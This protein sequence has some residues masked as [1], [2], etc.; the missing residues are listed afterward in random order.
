MNH[1]AKV[2]ATLVKPSKLEAATLR[3]AGFSP[4]PGGTGEVFDRAK[5]GARIVKMTNGKWRTGLSPDRPQGVDLA[6]VEAAIG[7][8]GA[9][10]LP[11]PALEG[12]SKSV[13]TINKIDAM[14]N[15]VPCQ[16]SFVIGH[17]AVTKEGGKKTFYL[18]RHVPSG[19]T[20]S[21]CGIVKLKHA[22]EGAKAVHAFMDECPWW[23]KSELSEVFSPY[24]RAKALGRVKDRI[25]A[26]ADRGMTD[27][28][29]LARL[30][31]EGVAVR[32]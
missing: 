25:F 16:A 23:A 4:C 27:E 1:K 12:K 5:D 20:I 28:E 17:V 2:E 7:W 24:G 13:T 3:Q 8:H 26:W 6:S 30:E 11:S 32:A 9:S 10:N 15:L 19:R 22:K 14:G 31:S 18:V 21:A 29:I